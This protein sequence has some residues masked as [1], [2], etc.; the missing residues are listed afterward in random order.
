MHL[1]LEIFH[2]VD[3][4]LLKKNFL[5]VSLF[6]LYLFLFF[7]ADYSPCEH[8]CAS[9]PLISGRRRS[10]TALECHPACYDVCAEREAGDQ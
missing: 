8:P 4:F 3:G 6:K 10:D 2:V 9:F 1:Y 5:L 7:L